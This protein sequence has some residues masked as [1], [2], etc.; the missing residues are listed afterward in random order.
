MKSNE[1]NYNNNTEFTID[2]RNLLDRKNYIPSLN[3][4]KKGLE[5]PGISILF[6]VN[7]K[8]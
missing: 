3:G 1:M 2:I 6:R 4:A 8:F 5:E 7:Y